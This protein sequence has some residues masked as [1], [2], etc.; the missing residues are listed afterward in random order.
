MPRT[1]SPERVVVVGASAGGVEALSRLVSRLPRPFP[2][3]I[4]VV[5][6][7]ASDAPSAL[8][9]ILDGAGPLPASFVSDREPLRG[10]QI[11]VAPP[12]RHLLLED[13]VAVAR[14]GPTENGHRPAIDPL[15]RSAAATH[16]E[17]AAGVILSGALDDGVLGLGA[18]KRAHGKAYAQ[19]PGEAQ[20]PSMPLHAIAQV[21]L[22]GVLTLDELADTLT[23]FARAPTPI[24]S[25]AD[26][27]TT[28]DASGGTMDPRPD[29]G[30]DM[31]RLDRVG[32][33]T[34]LTCPACGGAIWEVDQGGVTELRC[35]VG[36]AYGIDSF[37]SE[38]GNAVEQA[39]WSA[40][41]ALEE[42]EELLERLGERARA[43]GQPRS[44]RAFSER[45]AEMRESVE[46]VRRVA[47]S[48]P[49]VD[50]SAPADD[51]E[52]PA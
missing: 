51:Q 28:D 34:R 33:L 23:A 50:T 13:G 24:G 47:L 44:A 49:T 52:L 21:S 31:D 37:A 32:E 5:L 1:G 11:L 17:R 6:H 27:A 15:F 30:D 39:L 45:A 38:Q 29:E 4:L 18:I 26:R 9:R 14:A 12:G 43:N 3:T 35:H 22:D 10:G 41:R 20:H 48:A 2:A 46:A 36:H 42:K 16:G 8:A 25:S 40:V 19:H 7:L